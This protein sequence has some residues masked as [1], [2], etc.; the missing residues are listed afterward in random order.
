MGS[1]SFPIRCNRAVDERSEIITATEATAGDINEAHLMIP[2]IEQHKM[3]T[4]VTADTVVAD[5]KYGTIENF[6]SCHDRGIY[7]HIPDLRE[8]AVKRTVKLN[9]FSE[10]HFLYDTERDVYHLSSG[11]CAEAEIV[12]CEPPEQG[13]CR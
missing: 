4:G 10:D 3:T 8:A 6:L 5:S 2:L 11:K 9:I 7:A 13:L 12:A 1:L